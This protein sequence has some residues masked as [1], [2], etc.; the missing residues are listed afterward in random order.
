M[1]G[2]RVDCKAWEESEAKAAVGNTTTIADGGYPGTGLLMPTGAAREKDYLN[3]A[4]HT[5]SSTNSAAPVSSTTS[6]K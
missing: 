3:G 6:L 4:R 2:N 5:T 1:T